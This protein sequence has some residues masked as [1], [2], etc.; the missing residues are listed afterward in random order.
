MREK[1]L[2]AGN[3]NSGKTMAIIQLAVQV[4]ERTVYAFDAE[5]DINLTLEELGLELPNLIVKNVIPDWDKL[6]A[7]YREA[8]SVLTP[9]DW[10]CFDMMGVFWDLAQNSF[11]RAVF[12][13]SPSQHIIALRRESGKADFGGFDGL[14]D[15]T[16]I[17]RMHNEDI[18]DDALRWSPFNVLATTGLTD[19]SPKEKVP[20]TG[21]EGLMAKEFGQKLEG[22]RHNK[23]R[24]RTIAVIYQRLTDGRFCF[25]LVKLKGGAVFHPLSEFDFTGRSFFEVYQETKEIQE[26]GN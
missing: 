1:I 15:W 21:V 13:E 24:F 5:G 9:D 25:K 6:T 18:F 12:G 17:K 8:K 2:I 11:S 23:Y 4:P 7:D 16:V 10:C 20:K 14:T 26:G 3:T 22:E 19:F